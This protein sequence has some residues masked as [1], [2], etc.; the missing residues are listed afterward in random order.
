MAACLCFHTLTGGR[1]SVKND[2]GISNPY[3][4]DKHHEEA[5]AMTE[6]KAQ[7]EDKLNQVRRCVSEGE[8]EML[9]IAC[10]A[11]NSERLLQV[12]RHL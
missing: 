6:T 5:S 4:S 12:R 8:Q 7:L 9:R 3:E 1:D 10:L 2:R 11:S